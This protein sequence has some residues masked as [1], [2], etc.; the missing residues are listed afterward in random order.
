MSVVVTCTISAACAPVGEDILVVFNQLYSIYATPECPR[1]DIAELRKRLVLL[2]LCLW[3]RQCCASGAANAA[4]AV[5]LVP[6]V[7]LVL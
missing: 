6:P 3:C 4:G 7:L 2:V 1:S 5:T